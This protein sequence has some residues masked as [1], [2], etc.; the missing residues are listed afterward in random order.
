MTRFARRGAADPKPGRLPTAVPAE[1]QVVA[2]QHQV[3]RVGEATRA[4]RRHCFA[5]PFGLWAFLLF[6]ALYVVV[7]TGAVPATGGVLILVLGGVGSCAGVAALAASFYRW[8]KRRALADALEALAP[9][10]QRQVLLSLKEDPV[11]YTRRIASDLLRRV[12]LPSEVSP[13]PSPVGRGTEVGR[14]A[15]PAGGQPAASPRHQHQ[16]HQQPD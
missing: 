8:L 3:R 9:H 4:L 16:Q 1:M 7:S 11:P 14:A 15:E 13:A 2:V 10:E 12:G 5:W 6:V